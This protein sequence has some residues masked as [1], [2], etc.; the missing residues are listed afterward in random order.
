M[1]PKLRGV[2]KSPL[3]RV[4]ESLLLAGMRPPLIDRLSGHGEVDLAG[5]RIVLT[6]ASSGIGAA[7][8]RLYASRGWNVVINY[9]RDA[10]PAEAMAAECQA[11]GAEVLVVKANVADDADCRALAAA[12][13][14]LWPADAPI[15]GLVVTRYDHVP[16]AYK[17]RPGRIDVVEASHPVPDE[18]GRRAAQRIAELTQGLGPDDLVLCLISGGGSALLSLPAPDALLGEDLSQLTP[19]LFVMP[20]HSVH[21]EEEAPRN[22]L[23]L[24]DKRVLTFQHID[25]HDDEHGSLWIFEDVTAER[26]TAEQLIF[27]AERDTLTGLYN[28]RKFLQLAQQELDRNVRM[29]SDLCLVMV[30][31]DYFKR[32]NDRYG[33]PMGDLVLQQVATRLAANIRST[34]V[35]ARIGGEEFIVLMPHTE[36]A[37][38]L[39]LAE[40]LRAAIGEQPL[41]LPGGLTVPMTTSVGITGLQAHQQAPLNNLYT[42]ADQALYSAKAQGRNQVVWGDVSVP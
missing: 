14:A 36:R 10:G 34:D 32:V 28:R 24:D 37:G 41:E 38:G 23:K 9:S 16:P 11:L 31:L 22:E 15:S 17:A 26:A 29:P 18:A 5:K 27:L 40:K 25:V 1:R 13:D 4:T 42:A 30:D 39:T 19:A 7:T 3:R 12:V 35:L 33:H 2:S 8:A 21:G 20:E 6:G